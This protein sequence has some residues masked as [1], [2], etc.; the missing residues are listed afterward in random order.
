M[1]AMAVN[2]TGGATLHIACVLVYNLLWLTSFVVVLFSILLHFTF[3]DIPDE[4]RYCQHVS[5]K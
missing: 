5:D 3:I 4:H 2:C 1:S